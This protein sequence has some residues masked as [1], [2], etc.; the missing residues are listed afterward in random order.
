MRCI[1][2]QRQLCQ[3]QILLVIVKDGVSIQGQRAT[4]QAL[5]LYSGAAEA[6]ANSLDNEG[7]L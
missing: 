4:A 6:G 3:A 2:A 7:A 5:A 1:V